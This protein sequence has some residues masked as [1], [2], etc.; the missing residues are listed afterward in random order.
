M[1]FLDPPTH[2]PT[3]WGRGEIIL[4]I[5]LNQ[6]F[7]IRNSNARNSS[8]DIQGNRGGDAPPHAIYRPRGL[9]Q[10]RADGERPDLPGAAAAA[11]AAAAANAIYGATRQ[12]NADLIKF[13]GGTGIKTVIK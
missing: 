9:L 4:K 6:Q 1:P 3:S 8:R 12:L 11:A 2:P 13:D 10:R 7:D 5:E